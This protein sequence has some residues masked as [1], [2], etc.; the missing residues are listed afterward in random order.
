L[1]EKYLLRTTAN[2]IGSN[3]MRIKIALTDYFVLGR[4]KTQQKLA[5]KHSD[6]STCTAAAC[7]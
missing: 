7:G 3:Y 2:L 4:S 5:K 1:R 6:T